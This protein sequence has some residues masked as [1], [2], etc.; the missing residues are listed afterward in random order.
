MAEPTKAD[1]GVPVPDGA[2]FFR[3]VDDSGRLI[4][5]TAGAAQ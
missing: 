2:Q 5:V 4:P 1:R 3:G